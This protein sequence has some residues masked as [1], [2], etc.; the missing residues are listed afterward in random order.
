MILLLTRHSLEHGLIFSWKCWRNAD[1]CLFTLLT[2]SQGKQVIQFY[3]TYPGSAPVSVKRIGTAYTR[4]SKFS[5]FSYMLQLEVSKYV[6]KCKAVH[7]ML[8]I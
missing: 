6:S 3:K 1:A 4:Y 5:N 8:G 7:K 2:V